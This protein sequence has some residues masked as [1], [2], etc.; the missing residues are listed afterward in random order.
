MHGLASVARVAARRGEL[1]SQCL[2]CSSLH[3]V[4]SSAGADGG[5]SHGYCRPCFA[6]IEARWAR[7]DAADRQYEEGRG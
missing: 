5:I 1:V 7:E 2:E 4:V 6:A 3:S